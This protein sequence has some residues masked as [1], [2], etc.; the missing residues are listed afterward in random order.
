MRKHQILLS[1]SAPNLLSKL[2][3]TLIG[4]RSSRINPE[5]S[6]GTNPPTRGPVG[7]ETKAKA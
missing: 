5:K 6:G 1:E 2:G 4:K 7:N 3:W